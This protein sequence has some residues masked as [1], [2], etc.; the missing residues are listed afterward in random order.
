M[1]FNQLYSPIVANLILTVCLLLPL[2]GRSVLPPGDR[3]ERVRAFTRDIEFDYIAW[4]LDAFWLKFEQFALGTS[5]YIP[6]ETNAQLVLDYIDLIRNI[7]QKEAEL[8]I[9]Y[10]DPN[11]ADPD[12]TSAPL[13][14]DL[15]ALY[16]QRAQLG[17]LAETIL[18]SQLR[19]ILDEMGLAVGGQ[20]LP[21]ILYHS[22]AI[23]HALIISPRETIRQDQNISIS[24]DITLDEQVALEERVAE[25]LN[26]STLI[27]PI[28][29]VGTYPTM[30]A[31]TSNLNWLA[32]VV[33]HEWI[34]NY[35][36]LRPLGLSYLESGELRTMNETAASIGGKELGRALIARFY[37]E[38]LPPEPPPPSPT[39]TPRANEPTP[40]PEPPS[41]PVFNFNAEMRETRVN[42]EALLAAGKIE[43]AEQ[44]MELRRL[45]FW[46]N[47]Y[48]IRKLN[49]AYFAFYGAYADSPGGAAG[50]DPVGEAVRALRA[51]SATL[52]DFLNTISWMSSFE[53][54]EERV[55]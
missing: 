43:E 6:D 33:A 15:A 3:L 51:Q 34:H 28:G 5:S 16:D 49:Q 27:V 37:P 8:A 9:L 22:T 13:R 31:Q 40:T 48:R 39:P 29:G 24:P 19:V 20:A 1:S 41:E 42:A 14:A 2:L 50:A 35:F 23:P 12:T 46:D 55:R 52:K 18:Q 21:P 26:V 10:T 11:I 7:Q 53:A 47:G 54:L 4:T 44:Y 17:P 45:F 32:E 38:F 30:V 36:T 25:S